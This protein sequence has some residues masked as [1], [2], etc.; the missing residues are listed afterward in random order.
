[1]TERTATGAGH[2][3]KAG[4]KCWRLETVRTEQSDAAAATAVQLAVMPCT[5]ILDTTGQLPRC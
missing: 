5:L 4:R 1:M 3:A 2:E